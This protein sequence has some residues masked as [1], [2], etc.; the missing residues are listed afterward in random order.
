MVVLDSCLRVGSLVLAS[1]C[2]ISKY[3]EN[4]RPKNLVSYHLESSELKF[5]V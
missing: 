4:T 2:E 5:C 1:I 3:P